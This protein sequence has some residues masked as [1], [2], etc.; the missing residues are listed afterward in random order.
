MDNA[1]SI[2]RCVLSPHPHGS[3]RI[4]GESGEY[5]KRKGADMGVGVIAP[6]EA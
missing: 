2:D 1:H 6:R 4:I 3:T 5:R